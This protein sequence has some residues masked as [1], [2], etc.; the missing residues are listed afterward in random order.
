MAFSPLV[1]SEWNIFRA[2]WRPA[3]WGPGLSLPYLARCFCTLWWMWTN[4]FPWNSKTRTFPMFYKVEHKDLF[5][6]RPTQMA[7]RV[8]SCSSR[9]GLCWPMLVP[10]KQTGS[11]E[12]CL[13]LPA[14]SGPS[15]TR[16]G[17]PA[18]T[19]TAWRCWCLTVRREGWFLS[20]STWCSWQSLE[21]EAWGLVCSGRYQVIFSKH[22]VTVW[23]TSPVF[24]SWYQKSALICIQIIH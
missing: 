11:R 18:S 14:T 17:G 7:W 12:W 16:A 13:P 19:R 8:P 22:F 2:Y 15:M 10:L 9:M 20:L 3:C 24:A 1:F 5:A 23:A 4:D 6:R 21:A